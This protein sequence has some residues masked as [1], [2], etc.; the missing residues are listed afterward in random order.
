M[1]PGG[2]HS[3]APPW[4]QGVPCAG[5]REPHIGMADGRW[6]RPGAMSGATRALRCLWIRVDERTDR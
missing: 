1:A 2:D 5:Y 6:W 3:D 4:P